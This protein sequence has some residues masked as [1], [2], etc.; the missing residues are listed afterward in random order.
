MLEVSEVEVFKLKP[1]EKNPRIN[2]HAV[3]AV[4]NSI[5][6]FG[7]NVPILYDQN[8]TIIAGHTRWKAA[9]KLG[10]TRVPAIMLNLSDT[11]RKAFSI[12]DNKLASL[13]KWDEELLIATL[14]EL[15][16]DKIDL[17]VLGYTKVELDVLLLP[18]IEFNWQDFDDYLAKE[19]QSAPDTLQVKVGS[20]L[21]DIVKEAVRQYAS[22]HNIKGKDF[23]ALAGKVLCHL[24]GISYE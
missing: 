18:P 23:P 6:S 1:W 14:E 2:D 8:F 24:L 11:E 3:E 4:A 13:A 20:K 17:P 12:A 5:K 7:F 21:K 9:Q 22:K 10:M 15:K 16:L 19:T